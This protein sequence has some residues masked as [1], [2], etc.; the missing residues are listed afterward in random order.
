[1]VLRCGCLG[2]S[3][4]TRNRLT[5]VVSYCCTYKWWVLYRFQMYLRNVKTKIKKLI[6][7]IEFKDA[8]KGFYQ[9]L[10]RNLT[11][12]VSVLCVNCQCLVC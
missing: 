4:V 3:I 9:S 5:P 11:L 7:D 12:N 1:M 10:F 6:S 2:I 8:T